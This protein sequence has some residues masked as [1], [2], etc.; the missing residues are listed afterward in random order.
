MKTKEKRLGSLVEVGYKAR[1][2]AED[3]FESLV[4]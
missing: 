1:K 4:Q 2:E 3:F